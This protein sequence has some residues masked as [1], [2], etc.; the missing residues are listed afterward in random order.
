[1][2]MVGTNTSWRA[3]AHRLRRLAD[4]TYSRWITANLAALHGLRPQMPQ[5][6]RVVYD[7]F[8]QSR[9]L[10]LPKR[11]QSVWAPPVQLARPPAQR[12]WQMAYVLGRA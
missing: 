3:R 5:A 6:N 9:G 12:I 8:C 11:L 4:G 2:N 1:S 10:P 7:Q